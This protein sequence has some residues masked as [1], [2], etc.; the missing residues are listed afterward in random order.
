MAIIGQLALVHRV[1]KFAMK[2][3][4]QRCQL[5]PAKHLGDGGLDAAVGVGDDQFDPAEPRATSERRNSVQAALSSV[6]AMSKPMISRVPSLLTA[7]AMTAETLTTRPPS[8]TRWVRA[9]I[10]R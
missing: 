5:A 3:V 7:V 8:L 6:V 4:R 1:A 9:S 10:H 2:W